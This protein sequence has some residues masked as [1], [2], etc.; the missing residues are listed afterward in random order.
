MF[1]SKRNI[2]IAGMH[3]IRDKF[4][5]VAIAYLVDAILLVTAQLTLD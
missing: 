3:A 2:I 1:L 4:N 5:T